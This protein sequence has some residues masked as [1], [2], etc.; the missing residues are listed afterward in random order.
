MLE[1]IIESTRHESKQLRNPIHIDEVDEMNN[2]FTCIGIVLGQLLD[3][4]VIKTAEH[5]SEVK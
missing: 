4:S 1:Q 3:D 5:Q 2:L